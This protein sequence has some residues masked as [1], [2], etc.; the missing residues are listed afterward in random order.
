MELTKALELVRQIP[1]FPSKG[2]LFHDIAPLL[3]DGCAFSCVIENFS[4][5][6]PS[7]HLVAGIEARGFIFASAIAHD[8]QSGF[9]PIRKAGKLPGDV[10]S[11]GYGLEYGSDI[12]EVQK[13][14]IPQG[15]SVILVDDV[16]ATGGTIVAAID[17]LKSAGAK[18]SQV[19]VLIEIEGLH[20]REVI[21]AKHSDI[22]VIALV[23]R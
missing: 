3:A 15:A 5:R 12:L 9:V 2:I 4:S 7:E 13:D 22:E 14:A 6:M 8:R 21:L 20:G 10:Y 23:N 19:L 18:V 11:Q 16:L 1:D 17:L